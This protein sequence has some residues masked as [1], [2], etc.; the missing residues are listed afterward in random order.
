MTL[1]AVTVRQV[2][3]P[4]PACVPPDTPVQEALQRMNARRIGT[5]LVTEDGDRLLGIFTERD[6]IRRVLTADESWRN[7]P[8]ADWMTRDP[9]TV[10]PDVGWEEAAGLL[11]RLKVRHLPVVEGGL[12]VGL[13]SSR[14]LIAHREEYFGRAIEERT[15]EL[16]R[17]N[18][19]LI[20]RDAEML[21]NLR[22]AGRLQNRVLLPQAPPDWPD[23]RWSIHFAPLDHLGGDYYDF[24]APTP[25]HLGFLIAD[26]SGHSIPA[27]LVAI[28]ARFGFAQ[29]A[30]STPHPGDVLSA[31]NRRLQDLTE[32]RF[33]TAFY[34]V[35]D[36]RTGVFRYSSAGHPPPIHFEAKTGRVRDLL[37]QGFMLGI[38]PE[39]VYGEREIALEPGD[40]L[41]FYTDGLV[42]ARNEIGELYGIHRLNE[43]V[44]E[45]GREPS[46]ELLSHVLNCQRGFSGQTPL[47][48]DVTAAVV[49]V[50][51]DP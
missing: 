51:P 10:G 4:A 19:Q 13:I 7:A 14:L 31:M 43:C 40:K 12:V 20:A 26:A 46:A 49:E 17:A 38:M 42:E 6:L 32:E 27:A 30:G 15:A 34:G 47:T 22:A 9:H 35:L 8:V 45:H 37:A 2:M 29:A 48:D 25:D 41:L 18:D 33:V 16:R 39:E 5:V 50:V 1:P 3:N 24:A 23:L 44:A 28:L 21:Y 36:R 11:E